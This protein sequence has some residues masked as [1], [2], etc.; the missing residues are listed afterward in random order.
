MTLKCSGPCLEAQASDC[1]LASDYQPSS[2][3]CEVMA[4]GSQVS[5]ES[6]R[7]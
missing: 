6:Y 2:L 1:A 5:L 3:L 4:M 7:I